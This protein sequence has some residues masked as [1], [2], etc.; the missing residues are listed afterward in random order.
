MDAGQ[1]SVK[2]DEGPI[3]C[4]LVSL[5]IETSASARWFSMVATALVLLSTLGLLFSMGW[6]ALAS[7]PLLVLKHDTSLDGRFIRA[8]FRLYYA[9]VML[10]ATAAALSYLVFGRA[11]F[12]L[13]MA[14]VAAFAFVARRV[15]LSRIDVLNE[16]IRAGDA[17]AIARFRAVHIIVMVFNVAQ[18]VPIVWATSQL[19]F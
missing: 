7:L 11:G 8:L 18:V 9:A 6:F 13:G 14:V 16:S 3:A 17:A 15:V 1:S 2:F 10:A 5:H 4:V 19:S 12:A